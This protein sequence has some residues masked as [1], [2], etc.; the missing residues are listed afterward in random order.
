MSL[1]NSFIRLHPLDDVLIAR[2]Q[3]VG[4]TS[5]D[6]ITVRG[7]IPAGHKLAVRDLRAGDPVRR[8]NQIIGFWFAGEVS[9]PEGGPTRS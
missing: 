4:G 1:Q 9:R 8:Y 3:L 2:Q 6:N 5:V 7:L